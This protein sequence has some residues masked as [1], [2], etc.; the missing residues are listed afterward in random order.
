MSTGESTPHQDTPRPDRRRARRVSL[1]VPVEV[2]WIDADGVG[3]KEEA[4]ARNVN[5]HGALLDTKKYPP[6]NTEVVLK[7][8]LTG[9]SKQAR[10]AG[11]RRSKDGELL[12]V[13]VELLAPSEIF[14]GLT[15]QLQSSTAQLLEIERALQSRD[16]DFRVLRE[17]REAVEYLRKTASAVRQ[18]QDLQLGGGDPYSVLPV[19]TDVR[20]R[21]AVQLFDELAADLDAREVTDA[22]E[23]IDDVALAVDRLYQRL[24]DRAAT[25][26]GNRVEVHVPGSDERRF[27]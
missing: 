16:I 18:W 3:F 7:N 12:G 15:F 10:L 27:R 9:E 17:L 25:L 8:C 19:V 23:G 2:E 20:L 24:A 13:I 22:T 6:L 21:R 11:I 1:V 26:K 14:W 4:R 5:D